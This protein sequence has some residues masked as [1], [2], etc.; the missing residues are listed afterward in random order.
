MKKSSA[1]WLRNGSNKVISRQQDTK[2]EN[3]SKCFPFVQKATVALE[4]ET[5]RRDRSVRE[6]ANFT[7]AFE[8]KLGCKSV[9][10]QANK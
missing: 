6:M 7:S 9:G 3:E 4:K 1:A 5:N 2:R 8:M 10:P